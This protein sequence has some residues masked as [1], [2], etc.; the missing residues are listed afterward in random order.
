MGKAGYIAQK[1]A[2]T[3]CSTK[4][5]AAFIHPGESAHGDLGLV[6]EHDCIFA[7]STSSKTTEV[8]EMIELSRH[9]GGKTGHWC[10]I[11]PQ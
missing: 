9:L 11:T 7:F 2:A 6:D 5:P 4:T 10:D 1:F 3:L 8:L